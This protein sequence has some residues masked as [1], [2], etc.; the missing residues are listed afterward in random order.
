MP[1][2]EY[3][4][5]YPIRPVISITVPKTNAIILSVP[6]KTVKPRIISKTPATLRI[7]LSKFPS[8]C[9]IIISF[10]LLKPSTLLNCTLLNPTMYSDS[11]SS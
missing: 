6:V 5:Q 11:P 3:K 4:A 7:F 1:R 9:L 2:M 10:Y 8:F